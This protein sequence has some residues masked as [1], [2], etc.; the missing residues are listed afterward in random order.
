MDN[1]E[2]VILSRWHFDHCGDLAALP[3][4][5]NLLVGPGFKKAFLPGW[6]AN[7]KSPFREA[8]FEGRETIEIPFSSEILKIGGFEARDYFGD[9]SLYIL[10]VPGHAAAHICALVR[11]TKDTFVFLG[12]D[13]CH[14]GGVL[15]PSAYERLPDMLPTSTPLDEWL[16]SPCPC[17]MFT[18]SHPAQSNCRE[19]PFY[20]ISEGSATWYDDPKTAQK[21]V[22]FLQEFDADPNVLVAISHDA[23]ASKVCEFFLE[24]TMNDWQKKGWKEALHWGFLD[25]FSFEGKGEQYT[26]VDGL[27]KDRKRVIV[28]LLNFVLSVLNNAINTLF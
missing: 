20:K 7:E 14:F 26:L 12:G 25:E 6:P 1:I 18:P 23:T 15:R 4:A 5:I 11:T 21:S 8:Y 2:A 10:N 24:G 13:S 17:S 27:Y 22:A 3:K 16:P 9:G 28:V 19:P